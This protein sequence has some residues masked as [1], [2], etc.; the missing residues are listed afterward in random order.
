ME[1]F[2]VNF[3]HYSVLIKRMNKLIQIKPHPVIESAWT[4]GFKAER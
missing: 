2:T 3:H 1:V 4:T